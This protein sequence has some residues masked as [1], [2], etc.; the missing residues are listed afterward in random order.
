MVR[1]TGFLQK[2]GTL[3]KRLIKLTGMVVPSPVGDVKIVPPICTFVINT[4]TLKKCVVVV[5]VIRAQLPN[6]IVVHRCSSHSMCHQ[7]KNDFSFSFHCFI[8][9]HRYFLFGDLSG[10]DGLKKAT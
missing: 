2:Q 8:F 3:V 9:G 4:M 1:Q 10:P 6:V 7:G 5:V